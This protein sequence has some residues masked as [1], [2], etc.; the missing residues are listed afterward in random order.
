M[1]CVSVIAQCFNHEA[2]LEECLDSI[3]EQSYQD[4]ELIIIDDHSTDSSVQLIRSW[5]QRRRPTR[6]RFFPLA[7][8]LGVVRCLNRA[9]NYA[10]CE[11]ICAVATDDRWN[12]RY[13]EIVTQRLDQL[14]ASYA[15]AFTNANCIN[16]QGKS[17]EKDFVS[18]YHHG[19][20]NKN[21]LFDT[22]C[23][24][25]FIPAGSMM[26][27]RSVLC[28][29]GQYD[30]ALTYE[31]WDMW[32]RI[33]LDYHLEYIPECLIDYRIVGSSLIRTLRP[34][35]TPHTADYEATHCIMA[36]KLLKTGRLSRVNKAK[37]IRMLRHSCFELIKI[38]DKRYKAFLRFAFYEAN[39][40][41]LVL[42]WIN[43]KLRILSTLRAIRRI[44]SGIH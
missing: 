40:I 1:N 6:A 33:S 38:G 31:D 30:E 24:H 41:K 14:P 22:L 42:S 15:G 7:E 2:Y 12:K 44:F 43:Y 25:N 18:M 26:L 8:N 4:F 35:S 37:C 3:F 39:D 21:N 13:L 11:L 27:R 5:L 20:V 29:I 9:M 10:N 32:L 34:E 19:E 28:K 17:L 36:L 23:D 16:E